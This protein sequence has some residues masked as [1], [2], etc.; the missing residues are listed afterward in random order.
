MINTYLLSIDNLKY[1]YKNGLCHRSCDMPAI[2]YKNG[3]KE[4]FKNNKRHRDNYLPASKWINGCKFWFKNGIRYYPSTYLII[5]N[6][7]KIKIMKIEDK[8]WYAG[9]QN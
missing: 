6:V 8:W 5:I 2:E 3:T 9:P 7:M 1:W 4:W